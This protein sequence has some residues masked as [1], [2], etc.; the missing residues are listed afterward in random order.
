MNLQRPRTTR[1]ERNHR[2]L[3]RQN[4][5]RRYN[6]RALRFE[7]LE[8]RRCPSTCAGLLSASLSLPT[9]PSISLTGQLQEAG[10]SEVYHVPVDTHGLLAVQVQPQGFSTRLSL[11]G[12]GGQLLIQSEASSPQDPTDHIAIHVVSGDYFLMIQSVGGDGS[13]KLSTSFSDANAPSQPLSSVSGSYSVA[14]ADL[15]KGNNVPDVVIAD[16]RDNQVLVYLGLGDGTFQPPVAIPV[17]ES[18]L[19]VTTGDLLGNGIQDIITANLGSN[20][21]SILMGNGDGTF[22]PAIEV[23]AGLGPSGLTVGDFYGDGHLDLAVADMVGSDVQIVRNNGDGTFTQGPTIPID[24][25]PFSVT[26]GDFYGN[27]QLDLAAVGFYGGNLTILQDEGDANFMPLQELSA[28]A[29]DTAVMAADFNATGPPELAVASAG[30]DTVRLFQDQGGQFVPSVV[31]RAPTTPFQLAAADLTGDGR[32]DLI[33]SS[34]GAGDISIFTGN[35]DG[36]FQPAHNIPVGASTTGLAAA[37]LTGNGRIDLVT[38][39][40]ITANVYVLL[41]NGD[42]T[43]EVPQQPSIVAASPTVVAADLTGNG[44]EDLIVPDYSANDLSIFL[45]RGDGTFRAPIIVPTSLGPWDVAVGDFAGNG[46]MDLAVTDLIAD[47]ISILLGNGDGTFTQGETIQ[48]EVQPSYIEAADLAGNGILDLVVSNVISDDISIFYGNGDGTFQNFVSLPVGNQPGNV[49][50]ADLNGDGQPDIAVTVNQ[51][52]VAVLMA[53]GPQTYAPPVYYPAGAGANGLA[54]GDLTGSGIPDLVVSD[55]GSQA[56]TILL[57]NGDGT[58]RPGQTI[59]LAAA[60][61]AVALADLDGDGKLDIV[62]TSL[63]NNN[64]MILLGNGDGTFQPPIEVSAGP[65]P[66]AVAV[67]GL[68]ASG[69]PDIAV[70]NYEPGGLTL[71]LNQGPGVFTT[72]GSM[73]SGLTQV[74]M[75]TADFTDDGR[76]DIAVANPLQGTVTIELGNGDGTFTQGQTI[77]V[78]ADPSGLVAADF[79]GDGNTD[80]AVACAG[81]DDVVVLLGL[82]D[83]TFSSP[84]DLPVGEVPR[85]IVAGDFFHTGITDIAVADEISNNVSVLMGRGDGT[86]LPAQSYPVGVEPVALVAAD[87][88]NNGCED[89]VTANRTSGDLTI[90]WALPHGGFAPET[91]QYGGNAPAALAAAAVKGDGRIDLAV[92]D[93]QDDQITLLSN[94]GGGAFVPAWSTNVGEGADFL[95]ALYAPDNTSGVALAATSASSQNGIVL[96]LAG[97]GSLATTLTIPLEARP[98]GQVLGDFNNDGYVGIAMVA[99]SSPQLIVQLGNP[100]PGGPLLAPEAAAPLPQSPPVVV[101]WTGAFMPD[102]FTLNQQGELLLRVGQPGSPGQFEAPQVVGQNL[103]VRFSYIVLVQTASGPELAALEEGQPVIWLFSPASEPGAPLEARSIQVPNATFLV[104]MAAGDLERDGLDD[105]VVVDRGGNE[106][107]VLHQ[108]PNGSF[109]ELGQPLPVGYAA[110]NVAIA[111][112]NGD[113]WPDLV[114]SDTYSGD[115]SV[116]YGGPTGFGS[117]VLLS[118]GLGATQIVAEYGEL[119]PQSNDQPTGVAA[120]I[121]DRSGLTDIV[122]VQSGADSVSLLDGTPGGVI[123]DPSPA[124]TYSTGTDPTQVVTASLTGNGLADL[125]VLNQGSDD[126]SIFLNNGA[127]GFITMPRVDAGNEPTGVAVYDFVGSRFPDLLVSNAQGDL[128]IIVGNGDGT[129]RPYERADQGVSLALGDFAGNGK[130]EYVLSNTSIDQLSIQ[131]GETETFVQGRSQGIQAPGAVAVADLTGNGIEDIVVLNSGE[132]DMLI[133]LGLGGNH[134]EAPLRFFTGTDPVGLTIADLTGTGIPDIIVANAGSNDLS[135]FIGVGQ[136]NNWSLQPRPRLRVGDDPVSTAVADLSGDGIPDIICVDEGSNDVEVLRGVGGGFFSDRPALVLPAGPSPIRAFVGRFDSA[137]GLGL[138]VLDSGSSDLTYYSNFA[139]GTSIPQLVPTGGPNPVAAVMGYSAGGNYS[140]LF[141]A[142]Q[143]D[144]QIALLD[145]GPDGLT[146]TNFFNV[147]QSVQPTDL[148]VS[149]GPS[150]SVQLYIASAGRDQVIQLSVSLG[151]VSPAVGPPGGNPVQPAGAILSAA[152]RSPLLS[153]SDGLLSTDG[154]SISSE[155]Q[156]QA[157]TQAET[158]SVSAAG[159][160]AQAVAAT[161]GLG[162]A[163]PQVFTSSIAPLNLAVSNLVQ[164]GQVQVSD[165]MP[166]DHTALD[167]VAVLIVVSANSGEDAIGTRVGAGPIANAQ[168]GGSLSDSLSLPGASSLERFLADMDGSQTDLPRDVLVSP[169]EP[170]GPRPE[171]VWQPGKTETVGLASL[172]DR[173]PLDVSA[174][175]GDDAATPADDDPA[176]RV[177]FAGML[178]VDSGLFEAGSNAEAEP[179]SAVWVLRTA[180]ALGL[181]TLVLAGRTAWKSRRTGE[182]DQNEGRTHDARCSRW[183]H[184]PESSKTPRPRDNRSLDLPPWLAQPSPRRWRSL[185]MLLSKDRAREE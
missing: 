55:T 62:A 42:G 87:L 52:Q 35:G 70:A 37:D 161:A 85:A 170:S 169:S 95:Q 144:S 171:W 147:G 182:I 30:D 36:T 113:G 101:N 97:D 104:S 6:V 33:A 152:G 143:G 137:G 74:A 4:W 21:V 92:A 10:S 98:I 140:D 54:V 90:L 9:D 13:F 155:A 59:P 71:L 153:T 24:G 184:H 151:V 158:T 91:V 185:T 166:L 179:A 38:A 99:A 174:D 81:S 20:D 83:G 156:V 65:E 175:L 80:L 167:A 118:A 138:A 82:G 165:L 12:G 94:Q 181:S 72:A 43:F 16:F 93:E 96:F 29:I 129:F 121:I 180:G 150:G 125:V 61:F 66:Y 57:G 123:A 2:L 178:S 84:I 142:H 63:Q 139:S 22:Q 120:G 134:F 27:G 111:D 14:V 102:V 86:F 46:K 39:D 75:V 130:T 133:Y 7:E 176:A 76:T 51:S 131:Y 115:L 41:G 100:G 154:P 126:I 135:V 11:L 119:V 5:Q 103:G 148:A 15:I 1:H 89:L 173:T 25:N 56:I 168:P 69:R 149:D 136:A 8:C 88:S 160:S 58:F 124:M 48:S 77:Y 162:M 79:N 132:N 31:L 128:L 44:I 64:C 163:L 28:G 105:L 17:G 49:V 106:V 53:T 47:S 107:I 19:Y 114:V 108:A 45:G 146:L 177:D 34:Y 78:G 67:A 73:S 159:A 183:Q 116:Y 50:V 110:S 127:G 40:L 3:Q 109:S 145:G 164:M 32:L 60:P 141:I 68:T 18:P 117:E 122:S 112:L 157:S 26:A 172:Q 23:P